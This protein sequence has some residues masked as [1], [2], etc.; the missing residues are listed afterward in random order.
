MGSIVKISETDR[1]VQS[2]YDEQAAAWATF[3]EHDSCRVCG[4]HV[5]EFSQIL[6]YRWHQEQAK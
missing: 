6:H 1:T 5:R 2:Y 3:D 4:A